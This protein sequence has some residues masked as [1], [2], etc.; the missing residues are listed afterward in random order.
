MQQTE[1]LVKK[2]LAESLNFSDIASIKTDDH[3]RDDLQMDSMSSLMF[4]MKLEENIEGFFV[5]PE[6][7]QMRDLETVSSVVN[8]INIQMISKD[9]HVH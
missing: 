1:A 9:A 6:T 5:D 4:L 7:L 2:A 8:Y 3:L